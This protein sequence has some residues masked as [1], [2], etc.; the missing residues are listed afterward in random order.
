MIG[1]MI[2]IALVLGATAYFTIA[3]SAQTALWSAPRP[4]KRGLNQV[5]VHH[6]SWT[7]SVRTRIPC[8]EKRWKIIARRYLENDS[9]LY[10]AVTYDTASNVILLHDSGT[11]IPGRS[12]VV[13][14]RLRRKPPRSR[15]RFA[16]D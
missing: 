2:I 7:G 4:R 11:L 8:D 13:L 16:S 9:D 6:G 15:V 12:G 3:V 10:T 14:E 1:H 5:R